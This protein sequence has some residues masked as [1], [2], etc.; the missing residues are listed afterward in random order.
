MSDQEIPGSLSGKPIRL[1]LESTPACLSVRYSPGRWG[2]MFSIAD[3]KFGTVE[4]DEKD[5]LR[6]AK[7]ILRASKPSGA[8]LWGSVKPGRPMPKLPPKTAAGKF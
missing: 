1:P 2:R 6:M 7:D 4:L 5:A 8:F 3:G